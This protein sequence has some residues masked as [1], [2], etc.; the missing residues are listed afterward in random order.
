ME[1]RILGGF[2]LALDTPPLIHN[3][4]DNVVTIGAGGRIERAGAGGAGKKT[5]ECDCDRGARPHQPHSQRRPT[6]RA[7]RDSTQ[8]GA[9]R[10]RVLDLQEGNTAARKDSSGE[11]VE[12]AAAEGE[13][14][15]TGDAETEQAADPGTNERS[16]RDDKRDVRIRFAKSWRRR[17]RRCKGRA[18]RYN[19]RRRRSN[20]ATARIARRTNRSERVGR[21]K[22]GRA[23]GR[24]PSRR[25][26][27]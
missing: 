2:A 11:V 1:Q 5:T 10:I 22:E 3:E 8:G 7:Q 16:A 20:S 23:V 27:R 14:C 13:S 25:R 6:A 9:R 24:G 15:R 17:T 18:T 21:C 12:G 4:A 26:D 19:G